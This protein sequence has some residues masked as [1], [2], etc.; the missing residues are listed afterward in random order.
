M[1][2]DSVIFTGGRVIYT[3]R[4][5]KER[6]TSQRYRAET[7]TKAESAYIRYRMD[8][9]GISANSVAIATG[10]QLGDVSNVIAGRRHSRKIEFFLA[11]KVL[12]FASWNE[13]IRAIRV[14]TAT[15]QVA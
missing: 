11:T 10:V 8:L 4:A 5:P 12:G 1:C 14:I 2:Y 13:A 7:P 3:G 9:A 6:T 15:E